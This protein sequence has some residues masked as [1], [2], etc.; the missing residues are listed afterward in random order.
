MLPA[1][2]TAAGI[3][4][5]VRNAEATGIAR[6]TKDVRTEVTAGLFFTPFRAELLEPSMTRPFIER[7]WFVQNVFPIERDIGVQAKTFALGDRLVFDLGVINGQRLGERTFV[8]VPDLNRSKDLVGFLTYRIGPVTLGVNGYLGRGQIVD[9]QNLRFKQYG[10]W[11][12]NYQASLRHELFPRLG[13]SRLYA[14]LALTQNMDAGVNYPFAVPRIPANLTSNVQDL[15]GRALYVRAEQDLS[16]WLLVGY[17]Y[18]MYTPD[19]AVQNNARD[20]HSFLT[21][22]RF[23]KNLRWMNE[24]AWAIDNVHDGGAAGALPPSKQIVSFSSVLQA[25]FF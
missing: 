21:V 22:V 23:S 24:L 16:R 14:E 17:R 11:A 12:V 8:A 7:T 6:W 9:A 2:G 20:T 10:K 3:G 25:T 1:G 18:D 4:T 13:E 5:I 19:A 15:D